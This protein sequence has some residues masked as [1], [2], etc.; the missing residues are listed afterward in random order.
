MYP[1]LKK[2]RIQF[3]NKDSLSIL[4]IEIENENNLSIIRILKICRH[5]VNPMKTRI[6]CSD[7][8]VF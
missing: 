2:I 5:P 6:N 3:R 8:R 4:R 1:F 7:K